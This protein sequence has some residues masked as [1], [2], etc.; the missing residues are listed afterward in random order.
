MRGRGQSRP[1]SCRLPAGH[2][3]ADGGD[4]RQR[5]S[6]ILARAPLVRWTT[7]ANLFFLRGAAVRIDRPGIEPVEDVVTATAGNAEGN[8]VAVKLG[9]QAGQTVQVLGWD[10]DVDISLHEAVEALAGTPIVDVDFDDVVDVVLLWFREDDG[11]L[12]DAL[13][14]AIGPLTESGKVWLLTP[15]PGREGHVESADIADAAPTA[16]MQAT[17]TISAS[18]DWQGTCLVAPKSSRR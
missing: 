13:V 17:S 11:D 8:S 1:L 6:W 15:K 2:V 14:D 12:V 10:T 9:V 7:P 16:G 18:K 4:A 5:T 3:A